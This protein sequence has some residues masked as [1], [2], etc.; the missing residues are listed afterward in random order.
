MT[1]AWR[2]ANPE[3]AKQA[4]REWQKANPKRRA[5]YA[6]KA[7]LAD[8]EKK[9][10]QSRRWYAENREQKL[11]QNKAWAQ[12]NPDKRRAHIR[13]GYW[14]D[15]EKWRAYSAAKIKANMPYYVEAAAKRRAAQRGA[16]PVWADRKA[17]AAIYREARRRREAGEDVHVDHIVPLQSDI[18]CGLHVEFNL[19]IIGAFDNHSKKNR[20]WPDMP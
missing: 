1:A 14:R 20:H 2:E 7:R 3:R 18:V 11:E 19:R 16:T 5:E 13:S 17:I 6:L 10:A 8:P 15:P 9:R 4:T 12:A